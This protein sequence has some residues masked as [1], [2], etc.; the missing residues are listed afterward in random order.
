MQYVDVSTV[1]RRGVRLDDV[2]PGA[3]PKAPRGG[4]LYA[5]YVGRGQLRATCIDEPG[6]Y[7]AVTGEAEDTPMS[8]GFYALGDVGHQAAQ[9]T[10]EL[11]A[12]KK[13]RAL[14]YQPEP[15]LHSYR[16]IPVVHFGKKQM[17]L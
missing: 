9:R 13:G 7:E 12:L 10:A 3:R 11:S 15:A 2:A 1:M 6:A 8:R 4:H 17:I 16:Q 5:V 14:A